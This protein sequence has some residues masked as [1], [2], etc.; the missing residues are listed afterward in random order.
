MIIN[1]RELES[2]FADLPDK[3]DTEDVMYRLYL[4]EKIESAEQDVCGGNTLSH[5]EA[6]QRIAQ[7]WQN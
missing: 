5:I 4:I 1:K 6:Q 7:K 2:C 3:V